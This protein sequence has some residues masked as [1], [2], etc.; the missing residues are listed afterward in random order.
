MAE[1]GNGGT[2]HAGVDGLVHQRRLLESIGNMPPAEET[3]AIYYYHQLTESTKAERLTPKSLRRSQAVQPAPSW[4]AGCVVHN[5]SRVEGAP[6]I[7]FVLQILP[8]SLEVAAA[9]APEGMVR[10][11][12][13]SLGCPYRARS[14]K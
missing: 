7:E 2:G 12:D 1:P 9:S 5:G 4:W 11:R 8:Q 14:G 6:F 13:D 10:Q 3:E